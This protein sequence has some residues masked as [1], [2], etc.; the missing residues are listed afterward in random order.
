MTFAVFRRQKKIDDINRR[1]AEAKEAANDAAKAR[2]LQLGKQLKL[3]GYS[4]REAGK[5]TTS[6]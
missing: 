2:A 5:T 4:R 1:K 6:N 3:K